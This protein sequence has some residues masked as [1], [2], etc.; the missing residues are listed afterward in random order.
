VPPISSTSDDKHF[1][2]DAQ[3]G[4]LALYWHRWSAERLNFGDKLAPLLVQALSGRP[5]QHCEIG[6][7]LFAIGSILDRTRDGDQVWGTGFIDAR[8]RCPTSLRVHAVR[9]PLT[10]VRLFQ[11]GLELPKVYGDPALLLPWLV[12]PQDEPGTRIG[13]MPHHIDKELVRGRFSDPAFRVIDVLKPVNVVIRDVQDCAVLL[14]SSL[15][16]CVVGDAF[17]IPTTWVQLSDQVLGA[18]FKFLD[19]FAATGR[20]PVY[21][22]WRRRINV[23]RAVTAALS[24]PRPR[25]DA[26]A[27]LR[28][29]PYLRHDVRS[30]KDLAHAGVRLPVET[31]A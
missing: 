22:D 11:L 3:S 12:A 30:P 7:R 29:F 19:H 6:S 26:G 1:H 21:V 17:G 20:N 23:D 5:V 28:S 31:S 14:S 16:G 8:G 25:F 2:P 18:G 4:P 9:G 15:H 27:L 10:G 13:I 24:A